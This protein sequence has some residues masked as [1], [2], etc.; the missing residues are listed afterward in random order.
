MSKLYRYQVS[1]HVAADPRIVWD[2]VSDHA[3]MAEWTPFR[4]S[5][6]EKP[7]KP[8]PNGIGAV[9]ALYLAGPRHENGLSSSSRR[10]G[11]GTRCYPGCHFVTTSAR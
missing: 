4:R 11:C 8:H 5:V 9:R 3:G 2:V 6:V 10:D 7:G 1:R